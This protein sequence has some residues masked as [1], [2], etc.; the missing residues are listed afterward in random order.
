MMSLVSALKR[1]LRDN[2]EESY[3]ESCWSEREGES[4]NVRSWSTVEWVDGVVM[5]R[6]KLLNLGR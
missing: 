6:R 5:E 1:V 4:F 3:R 2:E